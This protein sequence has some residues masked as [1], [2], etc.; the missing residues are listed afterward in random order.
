[1]LPVP[2]VLVGREFPIS[3]YLDR[4]LEIFG[5]DARLTLGG[6]RVDCF[7]VHESRD[8]WVAYPDDRGDRGR[9]SKGIERLTSDSSGLDIN[10]VWHSSLSEVQGHNGSRIVI[11]QFLT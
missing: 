2:R 9:G 10:P 8:P 6:H 7:G 3:R 4:G 11:E 5:G 1:M